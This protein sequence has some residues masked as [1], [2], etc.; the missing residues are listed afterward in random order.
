LKAVTPVK[1]ATH[2]AAMKAPEG[3]RV[4]ESIFVVLSGAKLYS[5]VH[6]HFDHC[7]KCKS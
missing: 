2:E 6:N 1:S 5:G 3:C 4:F 7:Q